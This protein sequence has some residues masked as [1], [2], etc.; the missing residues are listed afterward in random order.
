MSLSRGIRGLRCHSLSLSGRSFMPMPSPEHRSGLR[1]YEEQEM[2][3]RESP[4]DIGRNSGLSLKA[5]KK[6]SQNFI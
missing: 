2:E 5:V 6:N 1:I 4:R 3:I